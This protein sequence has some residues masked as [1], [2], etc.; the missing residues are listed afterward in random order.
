MT[1]DTTRA[2][3]RGL[4]PVGGPIYTGLAKQTERKIAPLPMRARSRNLQRARRVRTKDKLNDVADPGILGAAS[5]PA[6]SSAMVEG[7]DDL[8]L[9]H[10][11]KERCEAALS[12]AENRGPKWRRLASLTKLASLAL[13]AAAT[14][15]LGLSSL[16]PLAAAGF[17][18]SALVTTL[19]AIEPYFNWRSRWVLAEKALHEWHRVD[20]DLE[21]YVAAARPI[22]REMLLE[23]DRRR[24]AT[25]NDFSEQWLVARRSAPSE[26]G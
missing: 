25:W 19:G 14:V 7:L 22:D 23:F 16:S 12:Y 1:P 20:D 24:A 17:V 9:A 13:S 3:C 11:V 21:L 5:A 2:V 8:T 4:G 6:F 18:C 15:I 10:M 26:S